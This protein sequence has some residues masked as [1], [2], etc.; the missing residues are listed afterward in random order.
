M[1]KIESLLDG[2]NEVMESSSASRLADPVASDTSLALTEADLLSLRRYRVERVR[3]Q[4]RTL[5]YAGAVFFDPINVRYCTD[6]RNMQV[7]TLRNPARYVFVAAD[8]P[9]VMFEFSGCDHLLAGLTEI[10]EIRT[11]IGWFFFTS[12]YRMQEKA[13][14]WAGEIADLVTKHGGGN[15]RLAI[16]RLL[17]EGFAALS[18]LG[19]T[20]VD[21]QEIAERARAIKSTEEIRC[22]KASID[23]CQTGLAR[24]ESKLQPGITENELWAVLHETNIALGGEYIETRLLTS[25]PR[26]NPWYQETSLKPI[27]PGE[28]VAVDTDMIGPYGYFADMSRSFLCG[29]EKP[30]GQQLNAYQLAYEQIHN[31]MALLKPGMSFREFSDRSWNMP[32]EYLPNRY[33]SLVHGAGLGG[34]YP[35]IPYRQDFELKGYDGLIEVDMTLCVESFIGSTRG[36]EG[37]KLEQLVQITEKGAV[38]LTNFPF[39]ERLLG[40]KA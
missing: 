27:Q 5:D 11:A 37:V 18:E 38:P 2:Q 40:G 39:D 32:E 30:I 36:G 15:R 8:G 25:G 4:L 23:V 1:T 19:I 26:T 10:D 24:L 6:S 33:M 22:L 12:G 20:V 7:W 21:G 35:Y 17:P 16:D 29:D 31:N 34:E 28:I 13:K 9:M 14:R 3:Q